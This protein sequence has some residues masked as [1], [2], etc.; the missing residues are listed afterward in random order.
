MGIPSFK[1]VIDALDEI[2]AAI[3][4]LTGV[5]IA[6]YMFLFETTL[7][8]DHWG[9]LTTLIGIESGYLFGKSVPKKPKG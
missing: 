6:I 3:I 8:K 7:L 1:D 4:I 9:K 5:G 2:C